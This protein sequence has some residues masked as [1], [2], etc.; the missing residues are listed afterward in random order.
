MEAHISVYAD[1]AMV[2][3]VIETT[4][5]VNDVTDAS[6]PQRSDDVCRDACY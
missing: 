6:S 3:L 2:H 5:R 4:A 1:S